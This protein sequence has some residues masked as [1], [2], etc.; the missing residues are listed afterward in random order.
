VKKFMVDVWGIDA[1]AQLNDVFT[2]KNRTSSGNDRANPETSEA[3]TAHTSSGAGVAQTDTQRP[4]SGPSQSSL[5]SSSESQDTTH[6]SSL[7]RS[8]SPVNSQVPA[9]GGLNGGE[10]DRRRLSHDDGM[11]ALASMASECETRLMAELQT[12]VESKGLRMT[13]NGIV[14]TR[15]VIHQ[16]LRECLMKILSHVSHENLILQQLEL[17]NH[18]SSGAPDPGTDMMDTGTESDPGTDTMDT[19]TDTM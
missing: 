11:R 15:D 12:W 2:R 4:T 3:S 5:R 13:E 18:A 9:T 1:K 7:S 17:D 19:G 8:R 10:G 14:Q 16:S 6:A